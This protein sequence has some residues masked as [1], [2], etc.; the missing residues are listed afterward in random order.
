MVLDGVCENIP[1]QALLG[2]LSQGV[3]DVESL[4]ETSRFATAPFPVIMKNVRN[5]AE[6]C[7]RHGEH[8]VKSYANVINAAKEAGLS[9]AD[10]VE[11]YGLR[12]YLHEDTIAMGVTRFSLGAEAHAASQRHI[13][14]S[15]V[16]SQYFTGLRGNRG[17][18][19]LGRVLIGSVAQNVGPLTARRSAELVGLP[20]KGVL[21]ERRANIIFRNG[22]SG[23]LKIRQ[24]EERPIPKL[25]SD[26]I[27]LCELLHSRLGTLETGRL[28]DAPGALG[29]RAA[30]KSVF[31]RCCDTFA[32]YFEVACDARKR[33][34]YVRQHQNRKFLVL[35]FY[36]GT[37]QGNVHTLRWMLAHSDVE[38]LWHYLTKITPGDMLREV[39]AYFLVDALQNHPFDLSEIDMHEVVF[40]ELSDSM[41]RRF[42]TRN[43]EIIES[44]ML[45]NFISLSIKKGLEILPHFFEVGGVK[46]A[47]IAVTIRNG[48]RL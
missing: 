45:E 14:M 36:Y 10:L 13:A 20:V 25:I 23:V 42:G 35:A 47:R 44:N 37:T 3:V 8:I 7:Y 38:H 1:T 29:M 26:D 11:R 24:V 31:Y 30:S 27:R 43:F 15:D 6:F 28:F 2:A 19:E 33:R 39:Q 18:V 21:D 9:P 4:R 46:L 17:L 32:D 5:A 40:A 41:E 34:W 12:K 16:V 22:K 48:S